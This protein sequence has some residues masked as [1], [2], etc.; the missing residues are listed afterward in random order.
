M[1]SGW[2]GASSSSTKAKSAWMKIWTASARASVWHWY[3][4]LRRATR[5]PWNASPAASA[6]ARCST[7]GTPCF[8]ASRMPCSRASR[9][10]SAST[11]SAARAC[12]WRNCSLKWWAAI[13]E[14]RYDLAIGET[15]S[16]LAERADRYGGQR[17]RLS[18]AAAQVYRDA[19]FP[20]RYVLAAKPAPA[21][22][23]RFPAGLAHAGLR[24][25]FGTHPLFLCPGVAARDQRRRAAAGRRQTGGGCGN[26]YRDWRRILGVGAGGAIVEGARDCGFPNGCGHLD[27]DCVD[28]QLYD[29]AGAVCAA[30]RSTAGLRRGLRGAVLEHLAPA[31]AGV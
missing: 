23:H 29:W 2:A 18:R 24:S 22:G 15:R 10:R 11:A 1:W 9:T 17:C 6:C 12:R 4:A 31:S 26:P 16:A 19:R 27:D 21:A 3:R 20:R 25:V 8:A 30:S 5:R 7:I 14:S 13:A 28:R